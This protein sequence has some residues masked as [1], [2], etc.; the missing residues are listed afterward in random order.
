MVRSWL[1]SFSILMLVIA[2]GCGDV[3]PIT[4]EASE[5]EIAISNVITQRWMRGYMTEDV[6]LYE[7]AFWKDGFLYYSDMGTPTDPSDFV[8]FDDIRDELDS[9][10]RV[11][12]RYQDIEIEV[13]EPEI[14]ML[15]EVK[16]V[17]RNHYKIQGFVADGTS[18]EGGYTGWYA[19]GDN[20][21]TFEKRKSPDGKLE[22]RITE[23]LDEAVHPDDIDNEA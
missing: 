19:E 16:A 18:L 8:Q 13:S 15:S 6:E 4:P 12:D 5:D 1:A 11:F 23:W 7:S 10:R 22:W 14:T 9:A 2:L 17:V 21:F 3:D 20:E